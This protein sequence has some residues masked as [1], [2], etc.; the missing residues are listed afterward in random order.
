MSI[1]V[2]DNPTIADRV[3]NKTDPYA[4]AVALMEYRD[5]P[6]GGNKVTFHFADG[7]TLTFRKEYH[8]ED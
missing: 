8:L 4:A 6:F 7:S 1:L 3:R 2:Q 5:A